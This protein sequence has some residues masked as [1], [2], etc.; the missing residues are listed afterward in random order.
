M[1]AL[2]RLRAPHYGA[3]N[4]H[5]AAYDNLAA[6][7]PQK[8]YRVINTSNAVFLRDVVS[9]QGGVELMVAL[10]FREDSDGHLVLPMVRQA[11]GQTESDSNNKDSAVSRFDGRPIPYPYPCV[12]DVKA[13]LYFPIFFTLGCGQQTLTHSKLATAGDI[14]P[15]CDV[16]D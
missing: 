12:G 10:G 3:P 7:A 4:R 11:G 9:V 8:Q 14:V 16:Q 2:C 5:P 13:Q 1:A 6:N 15:F